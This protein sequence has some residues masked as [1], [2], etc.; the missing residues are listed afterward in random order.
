M[1][2]Q[3]GTIVRQVLNT[4]A[5]RGGGEDAS[6]VITT[7]TTDHYGDRVSPEGGDL[8]VYL[9]NP[10]VL[11]AHA[12]D[13]PPVGVAT[14]IEVSSWGI[15]AA[16]RWASSAFAQQIKALWDENILRATSIG[17]IPLEYEPNQTGGFDISK[18]RLLEF[19]V[20]P[21]GANPEAVRKITAL[22]LTPRPAPP[23]PAM[24]L[25]DARVASPTSTV[26]SSMR[27]YLAR[28]LPPRRETPFIEAVRAAV[29]QAVEPRPEAL[30]DAIVRRARNFSPHQM[31][32]LIEE[33]QNLTADAGLGT[34][35]L[36]AMVRERRRLRSLLGKPI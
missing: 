20:V 14:Q 9:K 32:M 33:I 30:V 8:S 29:R 3:T 19:S 18:W 1:T 27:E 24:A 17:F 5:A 15:R 25:V 23:D 21:I 11:W 36:R 34:A 28:A 6:A 4:V 35:T 16:W 26:V 10:A 12:T 7:S 22:G 13:Q 2:T 31:T